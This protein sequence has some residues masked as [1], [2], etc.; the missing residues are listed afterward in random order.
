MKHRKNTQ[1]VI[2][3]PQND[4][5]HQ[6][7]SLSVPGASDDMKR[8]AGFID[9]HGDKLMDIHVTLDCHHFVDIA[10]PIFWRDQSGQEPAPFTLINKEDVLS[11][12][13]Q[14]AHPSF[15]QRAKD[16]VTKLE[17]GDRYALCIWP[18][19]CLIGS[20]G[21]GVYQ[22]LFESLTKWEQGFAMVDYVTKGSNIWTEHYSALKAD[23]IDPEDPSTQINTKI[24]ETLMESDEIIFAGE[25][26]SHCLANSVRDLYDVAPDLIA[27]TTL[28]TDATSPVPGFE[29]LQEDFI[30]DLAGKGMKLATTKDYQFKE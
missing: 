25:A 19:H 8:L 10:H 11:G 7:G 13:W 12:K 1:L 14:P 28:L 30:K 9:R 29:Q 23:V 21:N 4:F 15:I 17:E 22:P 24:I 5:C 6:E 3:D 27:K 2:I 16:Y 26:G 20:W 18:P